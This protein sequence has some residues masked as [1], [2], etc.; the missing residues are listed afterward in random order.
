MGNFFCSVTKKEKEQMLLDIDSIEKSIDRIKQSVANLQME[1]SDIKD[2]IQNESDQNNSRI[3]N[4]E[5][6]LLK[7]A[8]ALNGS[9]RM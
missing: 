7:I 4:V 2:T 1:L 5:N 6:K 8:D 3:E 9:F